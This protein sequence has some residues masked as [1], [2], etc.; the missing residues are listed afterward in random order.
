MCTAA[1]KSLWLRWADTFNDEGMT[2][3]FITHEKEEKDEEN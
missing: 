2:Y 3:L 1:P